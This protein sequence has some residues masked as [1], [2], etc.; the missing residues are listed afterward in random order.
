MD[1][2]A[3]TR[4]RLGKAAAAAPAEDLDATLELFFY[5]YSRLIAGSDEYLAK[6][7]LGR[8]HHRILYFIRSRQSLSVADLIE[9][10]RVTRQ[11]LHRP[12]RQLID[13]GYVDWE[14]DERNRRIHVLHLTPR[15]LTLESKISGMQKTL[16]KN[17]FRALGPDNESG[18][19]AVMT[20][21]AARPV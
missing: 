5:S 12:L 16:L 13:L 11:G 2:V 21:L 10:L 17:T 8:V 18:W 6:L 19:R 7:S 9:I 3:R 20:K 4:K 15:G 1:T 14:P